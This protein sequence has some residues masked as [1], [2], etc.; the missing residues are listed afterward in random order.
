VGREGGNIVNR[1]LGVWVR[2][3]G[4][5]IG[6]GWVGGRGVYWVWIGGHTDVCGK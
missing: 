6:G 5:G 4:V 3:G 1:I 2:V